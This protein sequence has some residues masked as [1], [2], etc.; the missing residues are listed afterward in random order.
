MVG[1]TPRTGAD[2]ILTNGVILS[3]DRHLPPAEAMAVADGRI[4]AVGRKAE[5]LPLASYRTKKINLHG[6]V[7]VPGLMDSHFHLVGFGRSLDE[8]D[9]TGTRSADEIAQLVAEKAASLPPG[10][11][12]TGR[13]W[14]QNDWAVTAFPTHE[15]LDQAAAEHPVLLTRIDGHAVW[16]NAMAM[17]LA[18][19]TADTQAPEGGVI[20]KDEHG[21]PT[22]VFIDRAANLIRKYVPEPTKE[23]VRRWILM[24]VERCNQV[25]L[26]EIHDPGV[27]AATLEI[28]KE[29]I[30][31]GH[32]TLHYYGMLDGQDEELLEKY[33]SEGPMI[34]YGGRM[35]VRAVKFTLDGALGS[36]GAALF[37]SYSD[38]PGNRGLLLMKPQ[39]LETL[40]R[41]TFEAGFQPGI[42]AIGDRANRLVLNI[43]ERSLARFKGRD[44]RPRIEH[45]QVLTARDVRRFAKLGVVPVMQA[46]HATSDMYWAEDRLGPQ[47]ILK[48]YAWYSLL[49]AGSTIAGGSDAPVERAEPLLQIYAARTRQD[50]TGWPEGGWYPRERM[51]GLQALRSITTWAAF[52]AF[53]DTL[54]GKLLPGYQADIT[55]LSDN[56]VVCEP[57]EILDTKILMTIIGGEIVWFDEAGLKLL[58]KAQE[59][60]PTPAITT[61]N[62]KK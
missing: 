19:I 61:G 48:A 1:C 38:D 60:P 11:W 33:L 3:M 23:D 41:R 51:S 14:D 46:S 29:L 28:I 2:L 36:R 62:G 54:R 4:L 27:N 55:I 53:A 43:Y 16:A 58:S 44:L 42:H 18:G 26:T 20:V 34:E 49:D 25:G 7:V 30:D 9:L 39:Q 37:A 57:Q 45:A 8:L 5:I 56:P 15:T 21:L 32:F 24:A 50:T 40:V 52:A 13:G 10:S 12:I 6:A 35:T 17:D 31:E 59:T 22:G 47:R